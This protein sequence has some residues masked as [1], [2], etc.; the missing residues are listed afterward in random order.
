M[1]MTEFLTPSLVVSIAFVLFIMMLGKKLF[2]ALRQ[3]AHEHQD[4]IKQ[5]FH[6]IRVLLQEAQDVLKEEK[7]KK[8]EK[9]IQEKNIKMLAELE[10]KSIKEEL[11]K[12][13]EEE[14][15]TA[16]ILHKQHVHAIILQWK[17]ERMQGLFQDFQA[18]IKKKISTTRVPRDFGEKLLKKSL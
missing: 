8:E 15:K 9:K 14:K 12:A 18:D 10:V 6:E 11:E 5:P 7:Q 16:E 3:K 13:I 1:M 17:K 2:V 4:L